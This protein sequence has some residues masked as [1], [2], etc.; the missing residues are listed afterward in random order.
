MK[1]SVR[2]IHPFSQGIGRI[3]ISAV[4]ED[5]LPL[6][7]PKPLRIAHQAP[8]LLALL[9]EEIHQVAADETRP[10]GD[11]AGADIPVVHR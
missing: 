10:P 6:Q 11:E 1:N 4:Q 3:K 8:H 5:G 9:N 2:S 7:P